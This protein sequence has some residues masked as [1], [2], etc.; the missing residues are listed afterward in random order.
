MI[1]SRLE[2]KMGLYMKG[3]EF[4]VFSYSEKHN[5]YFIQFGYIRPNGTPLERNGVSR[6]ITKPGSVVT[7]IKSK[8]D[9]GYVKTDIPANFK[10]RTID[11]LT[12][13]E[14][15]K[16]E[17]I[18][19]SAVEEIELVEGF[20]KI[21]NQVLKSKQGSFEY[22]PKI[23]EAYS[24]S[25][26]INDIIL[27]MV[28]NKPVLLTG[29]TGCGKTSQIEQVASRINQSVVRSNMN[30]QTT[31]G[32][33][34]GM[35]TVKSGETIWVDGV[36]PRAMKEGQWLVIDEI[37]CADPQILAVLNAVLE[38]NGVLTLKEKGFEVVR[39]HE[40]FRIFATANTVGCMAIFRS[41]YQGTNIM[42]EAFLD[43]FRVYH[44]DYMSKSDEVEVLMKSVPT[45]DKKTASLI[46]E[47]ANHVRNSFQKEELSCTFST[48]RVIDWGEMFVRH[49]CLKKSAKNVI[50]SK[51]SFEDA[52]VI[53][54]LLN[55]MSA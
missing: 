1:D 44:V 27:D 3:S 8:E 47:V 20:V 19:I 45:I 30:G 29:H 11:E 18:Q 55:R 16:E 12:N 36:L 6:S 2:N 10:I 23:N 52:K 26:Q 7:H 5:L 17:E 28:E 33:F 41:L 35:W 46:V 37:D 13:G 48:R 54:G 38:K 14:K 24:F 9:E 39:P 31:V 50:F 49:K 15:S 40:N 21:G 51:I 22:V 32:D 34:V 43:R 53:D 4:V 42:N 25:E